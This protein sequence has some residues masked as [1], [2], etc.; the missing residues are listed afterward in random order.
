MRGRTRSRGSGATSPERGSIPILMYHSLDESGAIISTHPDV[1]AE[2]MACLDQ[3]GYRGVSLGAAVS[4][5]RRTS[6]WPERQVGITFDDGYENLHRLAR[7]V[8]ARYAFTATAYLVTDHVGGRND[9][10]PLPPR[11]G[12]HDMLSWG[13]VGDLSQD[14]WEIGA[15]TRS[16]PDLRTMS[17]EEVEREV[18]N[19]RRAIEDRLGLK[20]ESFAYPF[21][22]LSESAISIVE[23]HF[24]SA[25]TTELALASSHSLH[26]LPRVDAYYLHRIDVFRRLVTGKLGVYLALRRAGRSVRAAIFDRGR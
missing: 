6:R 22:Y 13:Q 20:V 16:H 26:L 15:H 5:L 24:Q 18:E 25:C 11:F 3:N 1:F 7:P 19:S 9:W 4:E 2:Q 8:L 17:T 10:G 21:G 14:G 23:R 12:E